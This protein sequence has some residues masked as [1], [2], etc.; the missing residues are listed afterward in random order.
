MIFPKKKSKILEVGR[1]LSM[2]QHDVQTMP[3][4]APK[5]SSF[6]GSCFAARMLQHLLLYLLIFSE[7][8][9]ELFISCFRLDLT[10]IS[11]LVHLD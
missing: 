8:V 5:D 2:M 10:I 1:F 6:S 9:S 3:F 4:V 11:R 7:L